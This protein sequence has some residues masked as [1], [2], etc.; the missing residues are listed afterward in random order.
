VARVLE[1]DQN[2]ETSAL[3]EDADV[4]VAGEGEEN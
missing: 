3:G 1:G 2:G 4:G